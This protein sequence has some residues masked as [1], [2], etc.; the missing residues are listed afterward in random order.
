MDSVFNFSSATS[1]LGNGG[2]S[3]YGAASAFLDAAHEAL[4]PQAARV[5]TVNWGVWGDVGKLRDN[6]QRMQVLKASGLNSHNSEQGLLFIRQLLAGPSCIAGFMNI[7]AKVLGERSWV[8]A[9]FLEQLVKFRRF[10]GWRTTLTFRTWE[11]TSSTI[12]TALR[13]AGYIGI[14]HPR[15]TDRL[16]AG[17][18]RS[19]VRPPLRTLRPQSGRAY[20]V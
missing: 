14:G 4:F 9:R 15:R 20:R 5:L 16:L 6:Y 13:C 2:Q 8:C 3:T 17:P 18:L 12:A 11:S 1:I 10:P 7:D 19:M